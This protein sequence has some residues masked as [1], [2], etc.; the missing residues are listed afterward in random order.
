MNR[1]LLALLLTSCTDTT[2]QSNPADQYAPRSILLND[3]KVDSSGPDIPV[4]AIWDAQ[5]DS[6]VVDEGLQGSCAFGESR[7]CVVAELLLGECGK[8]RQVCSLGEWSQCTPLRGP[9]TE[10]CD[11]LDNDC[12]GSTD[13]NPSRPGEV[14]TQS[15]YDTDLR[16]TKSGVCSPGVRRCEQLPTGEYG[17]SENCSGQVL[18]GEEICD[19][20]DNDCNGIVDDLENRGDECR[21]VEDLPLLG[22]CRPGALGAP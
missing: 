9:R 6:S 11:G 10:I 19:G 20:L 8:G 22:E 15:C 16:L 12:D 18:P 14:L 1:V 4:I 5:V 17:F 3:A 2:T 7:E 13:E 21:S